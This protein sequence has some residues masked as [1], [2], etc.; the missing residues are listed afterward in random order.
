MKE[1]KNNKKG[2]FA[3][4]KTLLNHLW[5]IVFLY[6]LFFSY[7]LFSQIEYSDQEIA[8]QA[9]HQNRKYSEGLHDT[10]L[11]SQLKF[12]WAGGLN[13]CQFCAIDLDLDGKND[14]LIFDRHG[15]RKLTFINNGAPN[16]VD[17]NFA[18]AF[19]EKL[20][21]LHDWLITADYNRDG[22]MDLF[23]YGMGGV[24]VFENV[25]DTVLKFRMV[26]SLLESYYYTGYVGILVTS[27]DY[28]VIADIDGDGDL[29]MLTFFG[30]GSYV[31]YHKNLSM[32]KFGTCDS[33]DFRLSDHC[34]GKFKESEGGNR[35]TLNAGCPYENYQLPI[36]NYQL[37]I[38]NYQLPITNQQ[39]EIRNPKSEIRNPKSEIL[40]P[41]IPVQLYWQQ[42][43]TT[44]DL[45]TSL[46]VMLIFRD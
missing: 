41:V 11:I 36:T 40:F 24:R 31:E 16:M 19:S 2:M 44:T 35:I 13:S 1:R 46:W 32:E 42:I 10:T 37:P 25:S 17:Y 29:D 20:P 7:S 3:I 12:P 23:T 34:W 18:P 22:R 14:L 8:D 28:P 15:N 33:L 45:R 6:S 43:S 21:D 38:T 4:H 9:K 39:S 27:V 26:T 30:L 5:T